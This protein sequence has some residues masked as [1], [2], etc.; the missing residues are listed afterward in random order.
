MPGFFVS[1]KVVD[2]PLHNLFNDRCVAEKLASNQWTAKRNTLNKFMD[3]KAFSVTENAVLILDGV[4]LNKKQ[5]LCQ[6]NVDDVANLMWQ[7][8]LKN[9]NTFFVDFRGPFSGVLHDRN[10]NK[11]IVFTNHIGDAAV[12]CAY[13]DGC[14]FAGSQVNYVLDAMRECNVEVTFNESAAYQMLT[15]GF[16]EDNGTYA[17]EIQ[18]LHGGTYLCVENGEANIIEYHRFRKNPERFSGKTEKEI[19]AELD[20]AFRNA[21]TL[22][23]G[24]DDEYGYRYLVDISGGL[25]SRMNMWVA[26]M[27]KHR[28]MQL[29]TYSKANYLDERIA[30]Q[31]A[32]FWNDELL[33]KTLDD[34][35]Y[36]YEIDDI[37]FMNGGLSL[38]SGITGGKRML[39]T[40]NT[41]SFGLEHTGQINGAIIGS[42]YR[43]MKNGKGV[44]G[45]G[46][47]SEKL[48][49]RL[50][51][52]TLDKYDD[53]ELYALYTRGFRG[54]MNTQQIR[55]N[56]TEAIT[57][58]S[59]TDFLQLC[60]DIPA[61]IR[62]EHKLYKKWIISKYPEA[63]KFKWEKT[64]GRITEFA[65]F[66]KLRR[67]VFKGPLKL[68]RILG[69]H[70][71]I[72]TG[73]NPLDY[74]VSRNKEVKEYMDTYEANGYASMP[75]QASQQLIDDMKY[76]YKIGNINEKAM[77]LTVLASAKLYFGD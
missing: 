49:H 76:L 44:A 22:E 70:R 46:M 6:Y 40:I 39:E 50:S 60:L 19:I 53:Y 9:G 77:V 8:Y 7:M 21:S 69:L 54:I 28:H 24:K 52:S 74:W 71:Y 16:M 20:E 59:N 51:G 26:H 42:Y 33:V 14:F 73:M 48:K 31:V 58:T 29:M 67:I 57:T 4:L 72:N 32:E 12:Y 37:V 75:C 35:S 2:I 56:F 17:N 61:E 18:R 5:L 64:G 34:A 27:M 3:D 55:R 36:L 25:D 47:F 45:L 62:V 43:T 68:L 41:D 66:T 63:A 1:N 23:Y 30:K 10:N 65:L 15:F 38:Y 13:V 11:W